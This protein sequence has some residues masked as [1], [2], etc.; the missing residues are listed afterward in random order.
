MYTV[1][2]DRHNTNATYPEC[3]DFLFNYRNPHSDKVGIAK[4]CI[5]FKG[6]L[7]GV[8]IGNLGWKLYL[9]YP[10]KTWCVLPF[11][12]TYISY[13]NCMMSLFIWARTQPGGAYSKFS[14]V[15]W[16]DHKLSDFWGLSYGP[17]G[18]QGIV[19]RWL[20]SRKY[21][22]QNVEAGW[23]YGW[24]LWHGKYQGLQG[25]FKKCT[26]RLWPSSVVLC[27]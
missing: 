15:I 3:I 23:I 20:I 27:F 13:V 5:H 12:T 21:W 11:K 26:I 22:S 24:D 1:H 18:Q 14:R 2:T 16:Q 8:C 19:P 6:Y 9:I 7:Y 25:G 10:S 4:P 17:V